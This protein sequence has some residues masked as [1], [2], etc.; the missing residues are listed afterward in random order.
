[1]VGNRD[2]FDQ[3][4]KG[5]DVEVCQYV[6]EFVLAGSGGLAYDFYFFCIGGIVQGNVEHEAVELCFG[7]G[8]STFLFDG[9][10]GSQH[11]ERGGQRVALTTYRNRAFLHGFQQGGLCFRGCAVDFI[12]QDDVGKDW[13]AIEVKVSFFIH[14][15]R[16]GDVGRHEVRGK[17]NA[18]KIQVE[19]I[20][21]GADEEGFC[22]SGHSYQQAVAIA[23]QRYDDG[24]NNLFLPYD[25]FTDF[26]AQVLVSLRHSVHAFFIGLEFLHAGCFCRRQR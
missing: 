25:D 6:F 3:L 7:Q 9:V 14:D 20:G 19:H 5:Q 24:L 13:A 22:Q 4:L 21:Y 23:K 11:E 8:V 17:L 15:F 16:A 12:G 18:F 10:L 1:M 2:F 26:G